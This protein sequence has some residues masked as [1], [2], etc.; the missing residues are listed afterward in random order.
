VDKVLDNSLQKK[1]TIASALTAP[2]IQNR[3]KHFPLNHR[4]TA[5]PG[6]AI[7][8]TINMIFLNK[9]RLG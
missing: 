6:Q 3:W 2:F 8:G 5:N 4:I 9:N 1:G 7:F